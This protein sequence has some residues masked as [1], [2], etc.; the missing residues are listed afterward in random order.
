MTNVDTTPEIIGD[1]ASPPAQ[2][3]QFV[4][5]PSAIYS[6]DKPE[7]LNDVRTAAMRSLDKRRK[8][9]KLDSIYPLYMSDNLLD[10]EEMKGFLQ[11]VAQTGWEILQNQGYNMPLFEVFFTEAWCQEHH[12]HSSMDQHVHNGGNQLVGF[13]FL[14]CP[15]NCS[16]ILFH[17]PRQGKVQIN[18]QESNVS[19]ATLASDIINFDPK[20][21][22]LMFTNA[23]LPH[24]YTKNG[25]NKPMRFIH[26]NLAIQN[27][28]N[29]AVT[30]VP[31]AAEII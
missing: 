15:T 11:F 1:S 28:A 20:P 25:A 27:A 26:F 2:L 29:V 8:E 24:S 3:N 22:M 6:I 19:N 31:A 7:F 18:L 17:D 14:D 10:E 23:W 12:K 13:Y 4:Y 9:V 5:F 21:G 30:P 16:K